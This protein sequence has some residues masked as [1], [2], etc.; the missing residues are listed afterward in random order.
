MRLHPFEHAVKIVRIDLNKF[1]ILECSERRLGLSGQISE[2]THDERQFFQFD[3][4]A[5]FNV[6]GD[7]YARRADAIQF[8]LRTFSSH[9]FSLEGRARKETAGP[10]FESTTQ[11][12]RSAF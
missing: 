5:N 9:R 10:L 6:V 7:V 2:H 3:R 1:T 12:A 11:S 8:M 4:I